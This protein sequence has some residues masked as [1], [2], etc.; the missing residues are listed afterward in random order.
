MTFCSSL[1]PTWIVAVT[2]TPGISSRMIS[3][4]LVSARMK[5]SG[6]SLKNSPKAIPI[7]SKPTGASICK[8]RRISAVISSIGASVSSTR[9]K[10]FCRLPLPKSWMASAV[11]MPSV[12]ACSLMA[13]VWACQAGRSA[14]R[15]M[16]SSPTQRTKFP[17]CRAIQS[18]I[19]FI[20]SRFSSPGSHAGSKLSIGC[21]VWR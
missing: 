11:S 8:R 5:R 20:R 19:A 4:A 10:A 12:C 3:A 2:S 6:S 1:S 17:F 21:S 18:T 7:W 15:W 16:S 9:S 14:L 13:W